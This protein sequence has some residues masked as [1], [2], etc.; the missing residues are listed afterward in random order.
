MGGTCSASAVQNVPGCSD[1]PAFQEDLTPADFLT[2]GSDAR[3]R[4]PVLE[5]APSIIAPPLPPPAAL[6]CSARLGRAAE[7]AAAANATPDAAAG[8]P[9]CTAIQDMVLQVGRGLQSL[10]AQEAYRSIAMVLGMIAQ[11][12]Y[13]P[14]FRAM[15]KASHDS[16]ALMGNVAAEALLEAIG[17]CD[18]GDGFLVF[19]LSADLQTLRLALK[20]TQEALRRACDVS[21]A[22]DTDSDSDSDQASDFG[23]LCRA[24][25]DEASVPDVG[26]ADAADAGGGWQASPIAAAA[27]RPPEDK[28]FFSEEKPTPEVDSETFVELCP[29]KIQPSHPDALWCRRQLYGGAALALT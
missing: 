28:A 16:A 11:S 7:L 4:G 19:P 21:E 1:V 6:Q 5:A 22:V 15:D 24:K 3:P 26:E 9:S 2:P 25:A 13:E 27:A 29:A 20:L 10:E 18:T 12:P 8:P 14:A 17:F 23:S